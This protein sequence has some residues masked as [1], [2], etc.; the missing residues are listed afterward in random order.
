MKGNNRQTPAAASKPPPLSPTSKATAKYTNKDGSKFITVPKATSPVD[1]SYPSPTT[2][3]PSTPHPAAGEGSDGPAQTKNRKKQK[4]REKEAAKKA[5]AEQAQT[6][7]PANGQPS[8]P[9]SSAHH[10]GDPDV[11]DSQDEED[12]NDDDGQSHAQSPRQNGHAQGG[13]SNHKKSK[14]RKK[15]RAGGTTGDE[16]PNGLAGPS[17]GHPNDGHR[18]GMSREKLWNTSSLE[19]RKRIKEFWLG[20]SEFERKELVKVEKDA[21]L[22]K[23]KEQQKATCS[24]SVCGRKRNAIEEELEGLYDAYYQEL[25]QY[26]NSP[27]GSPAVTLQ[28]SPSR[29]RYPP[30]G[31]AHSGTPS[32]YTNH[33]P[34]RGQIVGN[35]GEL[36]LD[37]DDADEGE[38]AGGTYDDDGEDYT[39][40]GSQ[41]DHTYDDD[42]DRHHDDDHDHQGHGHLLSDADYPEEFLNFGKGLTVEGRD[43]LPV[44]PSF[45]HSF[46]SVQGRDSFPVLPS[47]LHSFPFAE[48]GNNAYSS[49][50]GGILTVA[51]DLLK[52]D[53]KK[54]IEMMEQ[55]AERRM[56]REQDARASYEQAHDSRHRHEPPEEEE[57]EEDD[58]DD[59]EEEEE[60][61]Y[62]SQ[63]EEEMTED[64]RMEEGRRMFQ[65]FAA[66]MFEQRVLNAYRKRVADE[67]SAQFIKELNDEELLEKQRQEK[68]L[69]DAQKRREKTAKKKQ[70]LAEEKARKDAE[71][72]AAEEAARAEEAQRAE[73]LR[74]KNEEK[75]KKREAQKKAEEE[76]RQRKE[77]ERLRRI[78]EREEAERKAREAKEKQRDEARLK[79]KEQREQKERE[80]R[81]RREQQERDKRDKEARARAS[82]EAAK[83]AKEAKEAREKEAKEK[84]AKEKERLR[85]EKE[86]LKKEDKAAQKTAASVPSAPIPISL[87]KRPAQPSVPTPV[88]ALPQQLSGSYS[89]PKISVATPALPKAPTPMRARQASQQESS[90]ASSSHS[91]SASG[92]SQNPSPHPITPVHASPGPMGHMGNRAIGSGVS[93]FG[94]PH[95]PSHP[96]S[97]PGMSAK[98]PPH[99]AGSFGP[100]PGM[101]FPLGM[102]HP[103]GFGAPGFAG[104]NMS[105]FPLP[106][107]NAYRGPTMP[108][109]GFGGQR[110]AP[111][112]GFDA[113]LPSM[114]PGYVMP[115]D[116]GP[117]HSRQGSGNFEPMTPINVSQPIARPTPIARPPSVVQRQSQRPDEGSRIENEA[118]LGS[119]VLLEGSDD[120][121]E[122]YTSPH[123]M[124][125]VH[126]GF[127]TRPIPISQ[128]PVSQFPLPPF[129]SESLQNLWAVPPLQPRF[130]LQAHPSHALWGPGSLGSS[131]GGGMPP[132]EPPTVLLR[133]ALCRACE[134]LAGNPSADPMEGFVSL[135]DIKTMIHHN[136][137]AAEDKDILNLCE[138]EGNYGNGG[139]SFEV[140]QDEHGRNWI[141]FDQGNGPPK[142]A[143]I[144]RAV[145]APG[146]IGARG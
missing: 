77:A 65:I 122:P 20:L 68:R 86:R 132:S 142:P 19:E 24:C 81:E 139:G 23:M 4:R 38:D 36:D 75:R 60:D 42:H 88:P 12:D 119:S 30:R 18:P 54:F 26:A 69:K 100:P 5:A 110:F 67:R 74:L 8:S 87:P 121:F 104:P 45:L 131:F 120:S 113:S 103:P 56:A 61:E 66:R 98:L 64:Q 114:S 3:G 108:P 135:D 79:E 72:A 134:N 145:G 59:Y 130:P 128:Y 17:R 25:E 33:Q 49:S 125:V 58:D 57:F 83:E 15:K 85:K 117:S 109:P 6:G 7:P 146:E 55:L 116:A 47:F 143:P 52:N 90:A 123:R 9:T 106:V 21:V 16:P 136:F 82:R 28:P 35:P 1:S 96:A 14:K 138:T 44:L 10:P 126:P 141:R 99:H 53:G 27:A 102:N 101:A 124:P 140:R 43:S 41:E 144:H 133:K 32:N 50:L 31:P 127:G 62:D 118:P 115:K 11:D 2:A 91:A 63:V 40:E 92:L 89:S 137:G 73:D 13:S 97:P 94:G 111:P 93:M 37:A 78:Q 129:Q 112:P 70:E 48:A 39:S 71:K 76:A 46:P 34:S 51:D 95:S 22:K 84:E 105:P 29:S 107:T 80:A